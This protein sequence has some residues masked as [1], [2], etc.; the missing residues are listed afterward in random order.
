MTD[1]PAAS[2]AFEVVSD[3]EVDE[4]AYHAFRLATQLHSVDCLSISA[5]R[6][7]AG[8]GYSVSFSISPQFNAAEDGH[9]IL[10]YDVN[11]K[12]SDDGSD[13]VFGEV[14]AS[15]ALNLLH[16]G[17][18]PSDSVISHFGQTEGLE[19]AVPYIREIAQTLSGRVGF[20][21]LTLPLLSIPRSAG[22]SPD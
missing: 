6:F 15:L 13:T 10:R 17:E 5:E 4:H 3:V 2:G 16:Q 9:I 12:I 14:K 8:V 19:L 18:V 1:Q 11:I 20:P 22:S 7:E 21:S